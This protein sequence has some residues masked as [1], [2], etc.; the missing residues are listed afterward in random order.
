M[1]FDVVPDAAQP[2]QLYV[3]F[4]FSETQGLLSSANLA[5]RPVV[6]ELTPEK[7]VSAMP[8]NAVDVDKK[9]K[10]ISY[11]IPEV[12][13]ARVLDGQTA[14]LQ[15]RFPVYQLGTVMTLPIDF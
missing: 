15:T 8:S 9:G 14:L 4:R 12:V 7:E 6:L 11:R 5:G 1:T 13:R 10:R 3:A 2:K